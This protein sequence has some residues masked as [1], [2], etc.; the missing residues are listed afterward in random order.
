MT[1]TASY[2]SALMQPKNTTS[3]FDSL[4]YKIRK[5]L[6]CAM[7]F[8]AVWEFKALWEIQSIQIK[9][10]SFYRIRDVVKKVELI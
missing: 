9:K 8:I 5:H 6:I 4:K 3:G 10:H 7:F 2:N 1:T